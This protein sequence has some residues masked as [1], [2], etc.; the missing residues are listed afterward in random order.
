MKKAVKENI[1]YLVFY[2]VGDLICIIIDHFFQTEFVKN[3][4][5]LIFAGLEIYLFGTIISLIIAAKTYIIRFFQ[6]YL[7][8]IFVAGITFVVPILFHFIFFK[9]SKL[10]ES[11]FLSFYGTYLTFFGAFALGY[12]LYVKDK[13][14][15]KAEELKKVRYLYEILSEISKRFLY[16][17]SLVESGIKLPS[18]VWQNYY[19]DVCHLIEYDE[20]SVRSEL[21]FFFDTVERINFYIETHQPQKAL[22]VYEQFR[23]IEQHQISS[24]NFMEVESVFLNISLQIKQEKPWK[25]GCKEEIKRYSEQYF[26]LINNWIFNYLIEKKVEQCSLQEIEYEL[27]EW[28]LNNTEMKNWV[29]HQ[30]DNRKVCSVIMDA[31][32]KMRSQS[33][34]LNFVWNEYCLKKQYNYITCHSF[35]ISE[36]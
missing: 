8:L 16:L 4:N 23:K 31:S 11:D 9:D 15:Q 5:K 35:T 28:L 22:T 10:Q 6:E 34:T 14:K 1:K 21:E 20:S 24:Y 2:L 27:T 36:I 30:Y 33:K 32:C 26:D 3:Y 25:E 18:I 12:V 17:D 19:F 29:K 13:K 7:L